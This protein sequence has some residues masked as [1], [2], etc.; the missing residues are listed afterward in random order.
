MGVAAGG[1]AVLGLLAFFVIQRRRKKAVIASQTTLDSS[2][3][4]GPVP[5]VPQ[6]LGHTAVYEKP[7]DQ[8]NTMYE[9]PAGQSTVADR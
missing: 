5:G 2:A 1:L 7:T 6:E 9:L 4:P 3:Q 8:Q